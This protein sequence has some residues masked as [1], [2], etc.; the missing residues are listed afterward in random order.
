M[1]GSDVFVSSPYTEAVGEY[2]TTGGTVS[3]PLFTDSNNPYG[4]VVIPEPS[5][6]AM[7]AM[8]G[9]GLLFLRRCRVK[10]RLQNLQ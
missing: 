9:A 6:W 5:T 8:G 1:S 2:T 3:V 7:L 4:I 10:A